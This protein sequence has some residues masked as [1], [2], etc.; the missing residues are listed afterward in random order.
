MQTARGLQ[1]PLHADGVESPEIRYGAGNEMITCI[2]FTLD[3]NSDHV[4]RVTFEGFDAIR[5]CRGEYMPYE[6]DWAADRT[7]RYPWV[8]EIDG[9]EWLQERHRYEFGFYKTPLLEEYIHYFFRFHDE[10]VEL[11]AKGIWFERV[12]HDHVTDPPV[13]HPLANLPQ[14]LPAEEFVIDGIHCAVRHN[15]LPLEELIERSNF[16]SQTLFQYFMTLGGITSP[17]YAAKLRTIR[18]KSATRLRGS[19]FY[20]D[21][22]AGNGVA[23]EATHRSEF[24]RYVSEVAERRREMGKTSS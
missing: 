4:G 20:P 14:S 17:S 16:C 7:G 2:V 1:V 6:D 21:L 22:L 23:L 10:Y 24:A 9:S 12:K 18:G 3:D 8:W 5:C 15:P 11:I 19:L 13:D